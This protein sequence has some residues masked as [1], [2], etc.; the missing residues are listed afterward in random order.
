MAE[1]GAGTGTG[2]PSAIVAIETELGT[3]PSGTLASVRLYLEVE[4][5]VDGTHDITKVVKLTATQTLTN[6]TL[7]SPT[8]NSATINSATIATS[9][10]SAPTIADFTNAQHDHADADDGGTLTG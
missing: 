10:L 1:L 2:Y 4:H 7:T 6:K 8:I 5:G 3:A 9:T